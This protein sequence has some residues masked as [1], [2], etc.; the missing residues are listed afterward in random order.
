MFWSNPVNTLNLPGLSS[1]TGAS[2][3]ERQCDGWL[4]LLIPDIR[5]VIYLFIFHNHIFI[6]CT[7][8]YIIDKILLGKSQRLESFHG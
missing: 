8:I 1:V 5:F 4:V 3:N 6:L 2:P 7:I